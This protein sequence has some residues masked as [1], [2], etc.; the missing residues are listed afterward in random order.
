M[1]ERPRQVFARCRTEAKRFMAALNRAFLSPTTKQ[2]E[3]YGR[4]F[5]NLS[6]A[7]VIA[8]TSLIF[9][10]SRYGAQYV[11]ALFIAGVVC[12][13]VGAFLSKGD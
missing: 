5:H 9:S 2:C 3:A 6:A 1:L 8:N 4:F 10:D 7:T 13:I 11:V 12:F